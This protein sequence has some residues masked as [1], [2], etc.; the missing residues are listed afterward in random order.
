MVDGTHNRVRRSADKE[1]RKKTYSG[2]KKAHTYN[3][4]IVINKRRV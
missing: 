1:R 2:K 4:N 3:T